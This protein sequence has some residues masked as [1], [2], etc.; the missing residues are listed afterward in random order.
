LIPKTAILNY[1]VQG[2]VDGGNWTDINCQYNPSCNPQ[3]IGDCCFTLS[4]SGNIFYATVKFKGETGHTYSGRARVQ[5]GSGQ[6]SDWGACRNTTCGGGTY[7]CKVCSGSRCITQ[8]FSFP[9][10]DE[11]QI[12]SDC[13]CNCSSWVDQGCGGN[14]CL[15]TEMYQTRTCNPSG[16]E[17]E[18]RCI[19]HSSCQSEPINI[20][21]SGCDCPEGGGDF[22]IIAT[23]SHPSGIRSIAI[24]YKSDSGLWRRLITCF[25][26]NTCQ[27][28]IT[29]E[30]GE[31]YR[32]RAYV[33]ANDG[34]SDYEECL[35][36]CP[37]STFQCTGSLPAHSSPWGSDESQNL[38]QDL[39]WQYSDSDTLRKC[40]FYCN[41]GYSWNGTDC[42]ASSPTCNINFVPSSIELGESSTLSWDSDGCTSANLQCSGVGIN[43]SD[44]SCSGSHNFTPSE[45]GIL[46]CTF[47]PSGLGGSNNCSARLNVASPQPKIFLE[48][49]PSEIKLAQSATISWSTENCSSCTASV[50]P[51][52]PEC[53]WQG[54]KPLSGSQKIRPENSGTYTLTLT[55][56]GGDGSVSE[57]VVLKVYR[58]PWW[59]I[60]A[61]K[62][63]GIFK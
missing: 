55:C 48:I 34:S 25:N 13:G 63:I 54:S 44:S 7:Q 23:A 58:I 11:C 28:V 61:S 40:E 32:I 57:S 46:N 60:L 8:T 50:E 41:D 12:D 27:G 36:T 21:I 31:S 15:A 22:T 53:N 52:C 51:N 56:S 30:A 62:L 47:T 37:E 9:C 14:S 5:N 2:K 42:V 38:T 49:D 26:A 35:T 43:W 17:S 29:G 1:Q 18:E 19:L 3:N 16:C 39:P 24:W 33:E 20:N 4:Q 10:S 6:W 45:T 59:E